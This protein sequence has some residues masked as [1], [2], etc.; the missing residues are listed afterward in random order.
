MAGPAER[1]LRPEDEISHYRIVSPLAA[2][3]M[4]EVYLAQDRS[5]ER[6]VALKILPPDLVKDKDRVRRFDLEA[7]S[8]SGLSHPNIVTIYEIGHDVVRSPG[9][10][11][12]DPVHFISMELVSGKTLA[13]LIHEDKTDLR[14]LVGYLA[15]AAEG[16]AKAHAAGIVHRDLKPG[17]IMVSA[18]GFTKVLDF[19]L[20]KLTEKREGASDIAEDE[21]M[22]RDGSAV[23][24]VVGTAGYMSPEQVQGKLVDHR[25]DIFS[26]GCILY[27]AATRKKPFAAETGIETM[28]KILN[29][30]PVP[31]E[32]LN[33]KVPAELRRLVKR[34]L[35]KSPDQRVQSVKD[36]AIELREIAEEYDTL[37]ASASS[38]SHG[39]GVAAT[40]RPA[41]RP[42][43]PAAAVAGVLV[44]A[45][46]A[47]G[48]W[49]LH[50]ASPSAAKPA[51]QSMRMST[52]TSRG[53]VF[54]A[55]ISPDGR[56]LAYLAGTAGRVSLR[57]RQVATG[58]DV[59]VLPT[60][61]AGLEGPTFSPD[62]NY[63]FYL[64][65]R[66]DNLNYR[67]LFEVASLG[68]TPRERV[69]DVDSR[70]C[71]S[72]DGKR[73]AFWRHVNLEKQSRLI[74]FDLDG[75][76]ES[77]LARLDDP[78]SYQGGPSWSPNGRTIAAALLK[79]APDFHAT[80]TLFD[81]G[82]GERRDLLSL[83]RTILNSVAWLPDG[84]GLAASAQDLTTSI[85]QQLFLVGYP[86]PQLQRVTND[87][88]RYVNV[89]VSKG[90]EAIAAVRVS[91]LANLWIAD[92]TGGP[93]R[94][95]SSTV[96]PEESHFFVSVMAP[97]TVVY[98]APRDQSVQIW[99][100]AVS[101]GEPR[102]LTTGDAL[103]INPRAARKLVVFDRLDASG[104]HVWSMNLDGSNP[105][106][107]SKG[108]GAQ[109]AAVSP[110]GRYAA[111]FPIDAPQ[112]VS[113][114][115]LDSGKVETL[116]TNVTGPLAGFSPDSSRLM[117]GRPEL[118]ASGLQRTVW[119]AIPVGG[120]AETATFRLPN[121][122]VDPAWAPDGQAMTFRNRADAA[123]NVF[124]L[125]AS[126]KEQ[127]VT[128]FTDG[129]I[130]GYQWSPDG[131]RLA[132]IRRTD[133]G[134]NVW[135]T[136]KDGS[137]PAQVTQFQSSDVFFARWLPDNRR[138]AVSAGKLSRDAVLIK[139]FR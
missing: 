137:R 80:V 4:G 133:E 106:K 71:F 97:D 135:V 112:S 109:A 9:A 53:D 73:I 122:A 114:I 58:S 5:L 101:G 123:W 3:G 136:A 37:S 69:F 46:L 116:A 131:S 32:E 118:D 38:T 120:G 12:S 81:A 18:D 68:G 76:K 89:S 49:A 33:D 100:L 117:V 44:L 115:T 26:F 45:G 102:T 50:R 40:A 70:A 91:R 6:N 24:S 63:V 103:S 59:E 66:P 110:D 22:A 75:S 34:C 138:L 15:Q 94:Q 125:D 96:N 105:R 29:E 77:V 25:S 98:D 52:Q 17:N 88:Y 57:V 35:A 11:D 60:R 104:V 2:G 126:G 87:F 43:P 36:L 132:L 61:D 124:R 19:G 47:V 10:A 119:Q 92:A 128:R 7:K 78:E 93:T 8:A 139:S 90:E 55:A 42:G 99:A 27:E 14:T 23:G 95:L 13:T 30:K 85:N 56:Y 134:A 21:T 28:H 121:T 48:W 65:R 31:V 84:Q 39:T 79:P 108:G 74:V 1:T 54:E 20:A 127:Q 130:T 111:Y 107:L 62:G 113:L 86:N 51:F 64:A 67:G 16:L 129:R 41:R 72:P 82:S 83:P